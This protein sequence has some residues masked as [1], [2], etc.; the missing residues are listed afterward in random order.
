MLEDLGFTVAR[1]AE[2]ATVLEGCGA[3][4]STEFGG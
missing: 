3:E 1:N 4:C 2:P